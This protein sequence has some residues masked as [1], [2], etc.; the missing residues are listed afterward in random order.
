[1]LVFMLFQSTLPAGGATINRV[2]SAGVMVFQSTL[3][4][5][6]ATIQRA[7]ARLVDNVSIHAPRRGSDISR[8][9]T[10]SDTVVSIHAPRRGSDFTGV[11]FLEIGQVSIHAPRRGSDRRLPSTRMCLHTFQSTLPAGGATCSRWHHRD[12]GRF[13]PRSPQGERR[14]L[15]QNLDITTEVSIHAP[16]RGSDC[17][18]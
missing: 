7:P 14:D 5:G 3:P 13:N 16:R 9:T 2:L 18:I 6:G 8:R 15:A 4:A 11:H 17:T 10:M 1:M 12:P